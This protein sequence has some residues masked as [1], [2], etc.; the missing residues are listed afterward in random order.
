RHS[1]TGSGDSVP[2]K[3]VEPSG[4]YLSPDEVEE[5]VKD[6]MFLRFTPF[7]APDGAATIIHAGA[8]AGRNFAEER[9]KPDVNI[10]EVAVKHIGKLRADGKKVLI[11]GWSEGSADRLVQILTEHKL[12]NIARVETLEALE[13]LPKGQ[14]GLGILPLESGFETAD[15][16][17][18]A[19]QDILGDRLVRRSKKKR[20]ASDFI[21]E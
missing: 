21:A 6:R 3:P 11:A 12:G 10:F 9:A 16:A 15:L 13:K 7:A 2:Y 5:A 19:E 14:A 4:L 8:S 18:V 17:V 1:G 20:K